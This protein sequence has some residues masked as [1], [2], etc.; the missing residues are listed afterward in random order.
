[1]I[2][3]WKKPVE[4]FISTNWKKIARRLHSHTVCPLP[5]SLQLPWFRP[6]SSLSDSSQTPMSTASCALISS[7]RYDPLPV[8]SVPD[9]WAQPPWQPQAAPASLYVRLFLRVSVLTICTSITLDH[10]RFLHLLC[11]SPPL[12]HIPT[13]IVSWNALLILDFHPHPS[14]NIYNNSQPWNP[15]IPYRWM[16]LS[17]LPSA[18]PNKL[19]PCTPDRKNSDIL[20]LNTAMV[21]AQPHQGLRTRWDLTPQNQ[22]PQPCPGPVDAGL[23]VW[24]EYLLG[25][26][27]GPLVSL[28]CCWQTN[29]TCEDSLHREPCS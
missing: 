24:S 28:L 9:S 13:I 6:L 18:S 12:F 8:G 14:V 5:S 11:I 20:G 17:A 7:P 29:P 10:L 15:S 21:L 19:T 3:T 16:L 27:T 22:S 26:L 23:T 2:S 4:V 1:M 25:I